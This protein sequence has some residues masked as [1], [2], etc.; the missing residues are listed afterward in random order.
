MPFVE[1]GRLRVPESTETTSPTTAV[2]LPATE[3]V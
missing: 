1:I 3:A 2:Y